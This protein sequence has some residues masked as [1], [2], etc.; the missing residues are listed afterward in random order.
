MY[1]LRLHSCDRGPLPW[2]APLHEV[3][4]IDEVCELRTI[5]PECAGSRE[6][7]SI[8]GVA[9]ST[10]I[11]GRHPRQLDQ[12]SRNRSGQVPAEA[13]RRTM[14]QLGAGPLLLTLNPI[15]PSILNPTSRHPVLVAPA[16]CRMYKA[17]RYMAVTMPC[18]S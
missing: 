8:A 2:T 18:N 6:R 10:E 14:E 11:L 16:S 7:N 1:I 9:A 15:K 4:P 12:L 3:L 5:P 17:P 13:H